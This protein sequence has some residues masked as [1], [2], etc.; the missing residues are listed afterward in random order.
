ME[1]THSQYEVLP[2]GQNQPDAQ[3]RL[4]L[5][6]AI[7][8]LAYSLALS[9][10][11]AVR[12]HAWNV[13]LRWEHWIATAA[14][15]ASFGLIFWQSRRLN[16]VF[17]PYLLPITAALS[18]FGVLTIFRIFPELG[19]RQ[20][21][22]LVLGSVLVTLGLRLS[23]G[24]SFLKRFKYLWLS[25]GLG[26]TALTLLFGTNP[27]GEGPRLWLG[28]CGLYFQPSEPLKLLLIIYLA[29]YLS[30]R[31][32]ALQ[33]AVQ[34][35]TRVPLVQILAP[36]L[37]LSGIALGLLAVQRDLGTAL[38]FLFLFA[39][40]T[41]LATGELKIPLISLFFVLIIGLIGYWVFDL[42]R[43]RVDAWINPWLDPAGRSYQIVQSLIAIANGGFLGRGPGLGSPG[44]VPVAH[45]DF[46]FAAIAEE[47]GLAGATILILL[48]SIFAHR[49]LHA[50]IQARSSFHRLLAAG[51]TAYLVGQSILIIAGNV[52]VLPLTGVTLPFVSYGGS[53]ML[54]AFLAFL[55]L[56]QISRAERRKTYPLHQRQPYL[57]LGLL[58]FTGLSV[59]LLASGWWSI[60]QGADLMAR[61]DNPRRY[62]NDRYARRGALLDRANNNLTVTVGE[63]GD[64]R[65]DYLYAPLS[66][67]LGY[68]SPVY[69]QSGLEL[70]MD[71]YLRGVR[72]NP[73]LQVWSSYILYG[74][75]PDGLDVRLSLDIKLQE[76]A[77]LALGEHVGSVVLLDAGS[78]EI[79]AMASHPGFNANTL[80]AD[81]D[82]LVQLEDAPLLNRAVQGS[83]QPGTA[84]G[85]FWLSSINSADLTQS[86]PPGTTSYRHDGSFLVCATPV[87]N[88][89]DWGALIAA[90]CPSASVALV[91]AL[92]RVEPEIPMNTLINFGLYTAPQLRM[93]VAPASAV[94][95]EADLTAMAL[96]QAELRVSPLQM[97][98]AY[99]ALSMDGVRPAPRITL[100]VDTPQSGWVVLSSL[101]STH[102]ATSEFAA[103][104]TA[105]QLTA[106][107]SLYWEAT[108]R[109][110]NGD[111]TIV[112][113]MA[114]TQPSWS[115]SPM[116]LVVLLEED[117]PA[118][119]QQIGSVL[120]Q[121]AL[122][123]P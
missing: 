68:T 99:A 108:A 102:I 33:P 4:L 5:L 56:L 112:W 110:L 87:S 120:M 10:S 43:L 18:G 82:R 36:A 11:P 44:L 116:T 81:W 75:H 105:N 37:L 51:L 72:G 77:D 49:G 100:A 27:L 88:P 114:G 69:G 117:D 71:D 83:Y 78:G 13:P 90:G 89:G 46:I 55:L 7:F 2:V 16:L 60:T 101:D 29:A 50:A 58:L 62:I 65:R 59:L 26:L 47:T 119:A 80:E 92:A 74:Q 6:T 61:T 34:R 21:L 31:F 25:T 32:G 22:W 1:T 98:L 97:A 123:L 3:G 94:D 122:V 91:E 66:P 93:Q 113:H 15:A 38:I 115:G 79:L 28:C 48:L 121:Q 96:G 104:A 118:T 24:L 67:I 95:P 45:S 20:S 17:D 52:R 106:P 30:D 53:S 85:P 12:M 111:K 86:P 39:T 109:A 57:Q 103:D 54:T 70:S 40:M 76:A 14:W 64:Y 42:V 63:S 35:S 9:I 84:L 107:E 73:Q 41:Y 23:P 8:V 19:L